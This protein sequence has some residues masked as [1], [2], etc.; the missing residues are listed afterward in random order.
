MLGWAE[1]S[2]EGT[3][4]YWIN[5]D[6]FGVHFNIF[7]SSI[8]CRSAVKMSWSM[9]GADIYL[10]LR[11]QKFSCSIL[12]GWQ[13]A[14]TAAPN[15]DNSVVHLD[16][17]KDDLACDKIEWKKKLHSLI[18]LSLRVP[19]HKVHK[20]SLDIQPPLSLEICN[21]GCIAHTTAQLSSQLIWLRRQW[22]RTRYPSTK[23]CCCDSIRVLNSAVTHGASLWWNFLEFAPPIQ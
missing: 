4:T 2:C 7:I 5:T 22:K 6:K 13:G 9:M 20:E 21:L 17:I 12:Y 15:R 11:E 14:K 1:L 8:S 10:T 23:A 16:L 3:N 19:R 18:H